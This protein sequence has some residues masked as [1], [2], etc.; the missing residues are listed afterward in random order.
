MSIFWPVRTWPDWSKF[1]KIYPFSTKCSHLI[2]GVIKCSN[3][4]YGLYRS[5][6]VP[7]SLRSVL[8]FQSLI[9][10]KIMN[11]SQPNLHTRNI[12][13][14]IWK[15][16]GKNSIPGSS[17]KVRGQFKSPNTSHV[18]SREIWNQSRWNLRGLISGALRRN[19]YKMSI[20]GPVRTGPN[21]SNW[22]TEPIATKF[23]GI[24]LWGP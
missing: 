23:A 19:H 17:V 1:Y 7:S 14:H 21:R 15:I 24:N 12:P 10:S 3:L 5:L 4:E 8:I 16:M 2:R 20:F 9:T 22:I 11:R 13:M 6:L 18:I